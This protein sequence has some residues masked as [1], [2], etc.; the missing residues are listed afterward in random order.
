MKKHIIMCSCGKLAIQCTEASEE[1]KTIIR[2][3]K[4]EVFYIYDKHFAFKE[5]IMSDDYEKIKQQHLQIS[6]PMKN[7]TREEIIEW[8][9]SKRCNICNQ[10]TQSIV[11]CCCNCNFP[12]Y[13]EEL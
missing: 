2:N 9:E 12:K 11:A 4:M 8:F 10:P 7:L 1:L 13:R 6:Q 3:A 5:Y